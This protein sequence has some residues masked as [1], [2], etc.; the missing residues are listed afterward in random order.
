MFYINR[1]ELQTAHELAEQLLRLAQSVQD[2]YLLSLAHTA[3]GCT[4]YYLG[5]LT[6]AR[7]HLEQAIA[8]YDP[9]TAPSLH[10]RYGLTRG[11]IASPMHAWT[12]WYLGYPDQALKRSHEALA[13]AAG[14]SHPFSLAYALGF[15]AWFHH[16]RREGQLARERAEAV[17]TLSTEQGFPYWLAYGTIVRG[18]ALAE[19][20]QVEEG[21]AQMR[22]GLAAYRARGQNWRPTLSCPAGRGVWESGTGR[23]RADRAG[24]GAGYGGQNWGA[25]LRGGAVSAERGTTLQS[26][27][28]RSKV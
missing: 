25:L 22:Q 10:R 12:L 11:W 24:R 9:Q 14:L 27:V 4:L 6:S 19:Q 8:L 18:W 21:I 5:E 23:G 7:T 28:Q 16:L 17:I 15:A 3:L 2:Q 26:K 13:L 20:G 1:G